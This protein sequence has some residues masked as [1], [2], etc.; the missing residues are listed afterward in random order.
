[1]AKKFIDVFLK[2]Y[3][4]KDAAGKRWVKKHVV[5]KTPDADGN[6]DDVFQATNVK[7]ADYPR[8]DPDLYE[9]VESLDEL[10][11]SELKRFVRS[12]S[13]TPNE[14]VGKKKLKKD[15]LKQEEA[16]NLDEL[17]RQTLM[18][19]SRK[20]AFD[21]ADTARNGGTRPGTRESRKIMKRAGGVAT[22][23]QKLGGN[24]LRVGPTKESLDPS[25]G[26]DAYID[27]FVHS[28]N[29]K[30]AGKS[31]KERI[32]MAL[33]AYYSAKNESITEEQLDELS[34]KT[35]ASYVIKAAD[36]YNNLGWEDG[37]S[38]PDMDRAARKKMRKQQRNKMY[39]IS[40][41]AHKMSGRRE[42]DA[43]VLAKEE[44]LDELSKATLV[45]YIN[46]AHQDTTDN[47][48]HRKYHLGHFVKGKVGELE[49]GS[50]RKGLD[51]MEARRTQDI[52]NRRRGIAAAT[53]KL[54]KEEILDEK[55]LTTSDREHMSS[56]TFGLPKQRKYP[57]PDKEHA[58]LAKAYAARYASPAER[59]Q[60]DRKA[61][62]KLGE[63]TLDELSAQ[64]LGRYI[65]H[66]AADNYV[67]GHNN[68]EKRAI[69]RITGVA[70]AAGR[71]TRGST[72]PEKK[73]VYLPYR[74]EAEQI[75]ELS[76]KKLG[77]Y[78]HR[79]VGKIADDAVSADDYDNRGYDADAMHYARKVI[80]REKGIR[81]AASKI[82]GSP[83]KNR[84]GSPPARIKARNEEAEQ[85]DE[86]SNKKLAQYYI[87][88]NKQISDAEYVDNDKEILK[89]L[90]RLRGVHKAVDKIASRLNREETETL[91]ELSKGT[92]RRYYSKANVDA[93]MAKQAGNEKKVQKRVSGM[94]KSMDKLYK[95]EAETL[96]E[97]SAKTLA[98]Y[99]DNARFNASS[100]AEHSGWVNGL[101]A[102][103]Y[104]RVPERLRKEREIANKRHGRRS[105]G[106]SLAANKLAKKA[107]ED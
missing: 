17:S 47:F 18:S 31:K 34:R 29:P 2:A 85:I 87:K 30:F 68:D 7:K 98:R 70:K 96:D 59:A 13:A 26:S 24:L 72:K 104:T 33:G 67:H 90:K 105:Y 92:L 41:A 56:K 9:E 28:K 101:T 21:M 102:M 71:L 32:K 6:K 81:L 100:D 64:T 3:E 107:K 61:N 75:D 57:M 48:N 38:P 43:K 16:E 95:E 55:D 91:D 36:R 11:S 84:G 77:R 44:T 51:D 79:A 93:V 8:S 15:G 19:Y 50:I 99:I 22:A 1:M 4:P 60:I 88:A 74:E 14:L 25:M 49:R 40:R 83:S 89:G 42:Y 5:A 73:Q 58:A 23:A 54:T 37:F 20:A 39:G 80:N 65:N 63:E 62:K 76:N 45:R 66:A 106:I 82:S 78:I 52:G 35:L 86:I 10:A 69:R 53:A 46:K 97:L 12:T 94:R 27:D 103:D